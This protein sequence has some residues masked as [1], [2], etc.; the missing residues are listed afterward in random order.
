MNSR[1][2]GILASGLLLLGIV[3]QNCQ[4][5]KPAQTF[6]SS[7]QN[8]EPELDS[9]KVILPPNFLDSPLEHHVFQRT[10]PSEGSL[11]LRFKLK[12][13]VSR[14]R[15]KISTANAVLFEQV[16]TPT[17]QQ[18]ADGEVTQTLRLPAG[19]WYFMQVDQIDD[20]NKELIRSVRNW[21][22]IGDVF[23]TA[24]QSNAANSG[25]VYTG[26]N[27]VTVAFNP[28]SGSFDIAQDPQPSLQ[29]SNPGILTG[30]SVWPPMGDAL[31]AANKIPV[32]TVAVA[33]GGTWISQ[34]QKG[35]KNCGAEGTLLEHPT[36]GKDCDNYKFL[37]Q[38]LMQI[39]KISGTPRM[40]LWHQGESDV[41]SG[42]SSADYQNRFKA[43]QSQL[44]ADFGAPL[45]WAVA[46]TTFV[47]NFN[48]QISDAN[49]VV[50]TCGTSDL[51]PD[52]ATEIALAQD[53]LVS[54]GFAYRGPT[55]DDLR[56]PQ[57]RSPAV[58]C[59]H[60]SQAGQYALGLRWA[61]SILK[62]DDLRP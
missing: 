11:F 8:S 23:V 46:K 6:Q 2:V 27:G 32:A 20:T 9:Y 19:G 53:Q 52:R 41:N 51:D 59:I 50:L 40:I 60:F 57:Y 30:G 47:P 49:G 37:L 16:W 42:T 25:E 14:F 18:N 43:M 26:S 62:M 34:W 38:T 48:Q 4:M 5:A 7:L 24:G 45:K 39:Q 10:S 61:N 28:R 17:A 54:D 21:V 1:K 44:N 13:A 3:F 22:G 29:P 58:G 31:Y 33:F 12:A 35:A 15:V 55:S 36:P 56:P